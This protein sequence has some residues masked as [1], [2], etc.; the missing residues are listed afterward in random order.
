MEEEEM[1]NG[2]VKNRG[3]EEERDVQAKKEEEGEAES[4][5][6]G[7]KTL[8]WVEKRKNKED[9]CMIM[10][11]TNGIGEKSLNGPRK[12]KNHTFE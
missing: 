3:R 11:G 1:M 12:K 6:R 9:E 5:V 10:K 2:S 7:A 8:A 4:R